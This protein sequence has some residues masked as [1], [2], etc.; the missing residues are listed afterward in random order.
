MRPLRT[1]PDAVGDGR[2]VVAAGA[3]PLDHLPAGPDPGLVVAGTIVA[4]RKPRTGTGGGLIG[5]LRPVDDEP[6]RP[7]RVTSRHPAGRIDRA[8]AVGHRVIGSMERAPL[9]VLL[10]GEEDQLAAGPDMALLR[11]G[12]R[13]R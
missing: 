11:L 7:D 4:I 3:G 8:P 1:Q 2:H 10:V 12:P 5:A 9:V 13:D 6:A